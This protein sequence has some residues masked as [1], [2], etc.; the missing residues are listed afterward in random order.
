MDTLQ[1]FPKSKF[2]IPSIV[3][4]IFIEQSISVITLS[5]LLF[6]LFRLT[7][8]KSPL[9]TPLFL[10]SLS[11]DYKIVHL[12]LHL[13]HWSLFYYKLIFRTS[14]VLSRPSSGNV[15]L[16]RCSWRDSVNYELRRFLLVPSV[17][18]TLSPSPSFTPV[19]PLIDPPP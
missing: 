8:H 6:V 12:I 1:S 7:Q 16:H 5:R 2:P 13:S 17:K 4:S 18:S 19:S 14:S 11:L 9:L 15:R 10:F 3:F